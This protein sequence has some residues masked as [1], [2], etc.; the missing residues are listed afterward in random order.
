M[1]K[2]PKLPTKKSLLQARVASLEVF[3]E[4]CEFF[5]VVDLNPF[6]GVV[7]L[8]IGIVFAFFFAAS[9]Y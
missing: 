8:H 9:I 1:S 2:N 7:F 6:M 3:F 4:F 5:L